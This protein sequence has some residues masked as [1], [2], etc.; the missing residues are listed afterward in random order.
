MCDGGGGLV[1]PTEKT[2]AGSSRLHGGDGPVES[3]QSRNA[4]ACCTWWVVS[5]ERV[6]VR[7]APTRSGK[8]LEVL[9]QGA[10]LRVAAIGLEESWIRLADSELSF[11]VSKADA[12]WMLIEDANLGTLVTPVDEQALAEA[13]LK[14]DDIFDL[15]IH[16]RDRGAAA[17]APIARAQQVALEQRRRVAVDDASSDVKEISSAEEDYGDEPGDLRSETAALSSFAVVTYSTPAGPPRP[18]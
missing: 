10:V 17:V 11:M 8:V 18:P 3:N 7:D 16:P 1:M 2:T 15:S 6:A 5:F 9:R 13:G 12:A 14:I 4:C